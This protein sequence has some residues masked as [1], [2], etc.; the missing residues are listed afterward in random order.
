SSFRNELVYLVSG[1]STRE[2]KTNKS[3]GIREILHQYFGTVVQLRNTA[4]GEQPRE[5]HFL[6]SHV[7]ANNREEATFVVIVE[8]DHVCHGVLVDEI[9]GKCMIKPV[10][11][12]GPAKR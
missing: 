11:A 1:P 4:A 7:F 2:I 8:K 5:S 12:V 9:V 3:V 10:Y 6:F